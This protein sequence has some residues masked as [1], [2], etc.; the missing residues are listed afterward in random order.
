MD[1]LN[2]IVLEPNEKYADLFEVGTHI[3][4]YEII[5]LLFESK[6][7]L[8]TYFLKDVQHLPDNLLT[9]LFEK[10]QAADECYFNRK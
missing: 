7:E 1:G 2:G 4:I 8:I 9:K 5:D 10:M 3:P 6:S